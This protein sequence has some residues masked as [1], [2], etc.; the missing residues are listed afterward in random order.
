M[1]LSKITKMPPLLPAQWSS[2]YI[3][4]WLP[5]QPDEDITSGYCWFNYKNNV[6]RIDGLFNPWS[7]KET[8]HRLWMSEI[9]YPSTNESFKSKV[10]YTREDM[11]KTS[12]FEAAVLDDKIDPCHELILTQDVLITCKAEYVGTSKILGH[13]VDEW[14]FQRPNGKGPATYYFICDT[15][16]LVRMITGDPKVMASVRDFP[17]FNTYKIDEEIFKPKPLQV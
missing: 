8:G 11:N 6:C 17:N 2:S 16:H 14:F 7:E 15:N 1:Q 9:M 4:Y 12:E 3:S 5:M 10:S 13:D